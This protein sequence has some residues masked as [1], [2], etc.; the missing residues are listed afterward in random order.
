MK[1]FGDTFILDSKVADPIDM[2]HYSMSLPVAV[3]ITGCDRMPI[4][5]QALRAVRTYAPMPAD[6]QAALLA[7][8]AAKARDGSTERYKVSTHFDS[9]TQHP[10]YLTQA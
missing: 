10:N 5:Q 3:V 8:A 7:Q 6:R 4:L 9:T 1:T 2:L